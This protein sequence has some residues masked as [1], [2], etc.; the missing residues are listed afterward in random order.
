MVA[1][2]LDSSDAKQ[3][4][5]AFEARC[6]MAGKTPGSTS[7][8]KDES[9]EVPVKEPLQSFVP[10]EKPAIDPVRPTVSCVK[11]KDTGAIDWWLIFKLF[12]AEL[13]GTSFL[14]VG[15]LTSEKNVL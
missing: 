4:L 12:V 3:L 6:S 5:E 2:D 13:S 11:P 7:R 10:S 1:S 15:G 9:V 14:M 8:P